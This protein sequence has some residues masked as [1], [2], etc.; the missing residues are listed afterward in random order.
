MNKK[1]TLKAM[2]LRLAGGLENIEK[3]S[4]DTINK[5]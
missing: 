4:K 5:L 3:F 1:K 2:G